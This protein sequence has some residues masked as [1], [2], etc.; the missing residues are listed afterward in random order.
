MTDKI[1][2]PELLAPAGDMERLMAAVKYGAD[3]L[4]NYN[5]LFYIFARSHIKLLALPCRQSF[6]NIARRS[7]P[8]EFARNC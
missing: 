6:L 1:K 8:P 2:K 3:A 7:L 5:I 4:I